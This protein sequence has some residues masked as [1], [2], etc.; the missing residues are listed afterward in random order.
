ML[1]LL[2]RQGLVFRDAEP[3]HLALSIERIEIDMCDDSKR[4]I[5]R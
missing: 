4:A 5:C 1:P 2:N 3:H